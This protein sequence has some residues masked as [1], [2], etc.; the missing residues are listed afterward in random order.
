MSS[1]TLLF[2]ASWTEQGERRQGAYVA[3]LSP[4]MSNYPAFPSYDLELQY[5]CL[6]L[7]RDHSAVPVPETPWLELDES[8]LGSPFFVME[9]IEGLVPP[10]MPPYVFAGW[11]LEATPE[12][13]AKLQRESIAILAGLHGID[14]AG[15]DV[16]FLERPDEGK[17]A[18]DQH[19]GHER[20]YYEWAREGVDY[21]I[22]ERTFEWLH[23]NRPAQEDPPVLNWG[24]ARIG[25]LM[26]RDFRPVAA[27]DWEMAAL[28]APEADLAWMQFMHAF[29]QEMAEAA[30]QAGIPGFMERT[31]VATTYEELSGRTVKNLDYYEVFAAL[32]WGSISIRTSARAVAV[33]HMEKPDTPEGLIMCRHMLERM[34]DGSYWS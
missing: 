13:R 25:N 22:I 5:R 31:E 29:F 10:D 7:V 26:Y 16:S 20:T 24:D 33:G 3:R 21:P 2:D 8:K 19:L 28:G 23:A 34:I 9:K 1:E 14:L 6:N 30:G 32:R 15:V 27:F 11:V 12:Q 17:T 4:D 18:L